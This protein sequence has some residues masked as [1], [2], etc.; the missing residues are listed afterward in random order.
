MYGKTFIK[1]QQ[2]HYLS[3]CSF[4]YT[5]FMNLCYMYAA[6]H[7]RHLKWPLKEV[8]CLIKYILLYKRLFGNPNMWLM[9]NHGD[10]LWR[11]DHISCELFE[12]PYNWDK[13]MIHILPSFP[14][15]VVSEE[16]LYQSFHSSLFCS[17]DCKGC[18]QLS[19]PVSVCSAALG[20][21]PEAVLVHL[22]EGAEALLQAGAALAS[23]PWK[24]KQSC[25]CVLYLS[26]VHC[27]EP[28]WPLPSFSMLGWNSIIFWN[29]IIV[30][31]H[32]AMC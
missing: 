12:L 7:G 25:C 19:G 9:L 3:S 17:V 6:I 1:V 4:V 27:F 2:L 31:N 26:P 23:L 11:F 10:N 5:Y 32:V 8:G 13:P 16:A 21:N 29:S 30:W 14:L 18:T 24:Q 20:S 28:F 22:Y 15:T